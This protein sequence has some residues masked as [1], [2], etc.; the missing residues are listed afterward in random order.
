MSVETYCSKIVF[1][2]DAGVGKTTLINSLVCRNR[3][4]V[5]FDT[6]STIGPTNTKLTIDDHSFILWD[7][8]GQE[9]FRSVAPLVMRGADLIF[10]VC[11]VDIL[12][13][14][15]GYRF[16]LQTVQKQEPNT[17][18]KV[19][20]NKLDLETHDLTYEMV[21]Y[22]A[23]KNNIDVIGVSAVTGLGIDLILNAIQTSQSEY[24]V[25]DEVKVNVP[26][27]QQ[28]PFCCKI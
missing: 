26:S 1:I 17:K 24:E 10:I 3:N 25:V 4:E 13:S 6:Q 8:A 9:R 15:D 22:E 12:T 21:V 28:N 27:S 20:L 2:G 18:V 19:L 16:W 7:T 23:Q 5:N 14:L 11:S